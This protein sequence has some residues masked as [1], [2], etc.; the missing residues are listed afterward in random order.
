MAR[1]VAF[2]PSSGDQ[3]PVFGQT[4][5]LRAPPFNLGLAEAEESL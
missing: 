2:V 3:L 5:R 4:A 1:S